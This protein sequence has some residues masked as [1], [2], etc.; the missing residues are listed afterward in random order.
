VTRLGFLILDAQVFPTSVLRQTFLQAFIYGMFL[1]A[2]WLVYS[3]APQRRLF[4]LVALV[5]G[6]VF[7]SG[8]VHLFHIYGMFYVPVVLT[9]G[10]LIRFHAL[11]SFEK[12]EVWFAI[13]ATVLSLW[14]PF[15]TALFIGFYFG[16]C[17]ETYPHR[18][19]AQR[20]RSALIL[21]AGSIVMV[22]LVALFPRAQ[23]ATGSRWIG[24]LLSYQTNE[25]NEIASLAA[26][27][28]AQVVVLSMVGSS[29]SRLAACVL[30]AALS[31]VFWY[32]GIP[33]LLIWFSAVL[34]KLF[35]LR[36]WAIFFL[37]MTAALLPF[38]GAIGT[39]IYGLFGIIVATYVTSL[40]WPSAERA[41][42][43]FGPRYAMGAIAAAVLILLMIRGGIQVP[44]V[45]KVA[46]PLLTERE[47]TFQL[48]NALAW[49]HNS[50]YCGYDISFTEN[51]GSP[52]DSLENVITRR[53]RPPASLGDVQFFWNGILRC[54]D[55]G[56][57]S[58]KAGIATVT[59]GDPALVADASAVFVVKG[60]YAGDA[61]V[62]IRKTATP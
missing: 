39:P 9:L 12:R 15:T 26:F 22:A 61:V 25:V 52:V 18:S 6:G 60:K 27:L 24:F 42:S 14:H 43:G 45:T 21:L 53:N 54:Q 38:G 3:V 50:E 23:V 28:L 55:A 29:R 36:L 17:L 48:E 51:A 8:Y 62:W 7:F 10:A 35:R 57:L 44:I 46:M 34:I 40:G 19:R 5:S 49:L 59:F 2:W 1:L 4:A 58:D 33:L 31:G 47:R 20:V 16:H 30:V 11:Q 37:M 41:L 13:I 32:A 56:R